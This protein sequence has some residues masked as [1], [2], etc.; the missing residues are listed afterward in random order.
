MKKNFK[1][2][3]ILMIIA[4]ICG[5][6]VSGMNM[7]TS[8][9][10]EKNQLEK[11]AQLCKEI[12]ADYDTKKSKIITEDLSNE[13]I[14]K[15]I[16]AND[17]S[18]A[19]LGYIYTVSGKNSYGP[20]TLLVGIS[21]DGKLVSIEFLENGQSYGSTVAEHVD[22]NYSEGLTASD[23]ASIDTKCGATY[24]AK[25]VQELVTIAFNDYSN[26]GAK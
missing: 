2:A 7:L 1:I 26:G 23:V 5:L 6:A 15:K 14:T 17:A 25:T 24:G 11:E 22:A 4:A 3:A 18:G 10:I 20:I 12:F 19:S 16:V 9:I 8:S 13:A 21:S